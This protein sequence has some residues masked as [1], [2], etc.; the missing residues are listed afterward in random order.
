MQQQQQKC[1]KHE[2]NMRQMPEKIILFVDRIK[3]YN[4][5]SLK[6]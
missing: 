1:N 2:N 3:F 4:R 6:L 5:L